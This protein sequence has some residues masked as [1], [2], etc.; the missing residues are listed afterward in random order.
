MERTDYGTLLIP[1]MKISDAG[2]YL[3]IGTNAIGS[4]EAVIEVSVI[5]GKLKKSF[6]QNDNSPSKTSCNE[7]YRRRTECMQ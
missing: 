5:K 7:Y 2:T 3:C 4:S 6:Q 1:D